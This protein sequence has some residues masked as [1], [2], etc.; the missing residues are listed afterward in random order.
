MSENIESI[1]LV[2]RESGKQSR[3]LRRERAMQAATGDEDA[4]AKMLRDRGLVLRERENSIFS[5]AWIPIAVIILVVGLFNGR[6]TA[7]LA[8]GFVLLIVVGVSALWKR[9]ALTG[10]FYRR[11]FDHSRVFP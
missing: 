7:L 6:N 2:I 3:R 11:S 10:V 5:D 1:H 8:L 4:L 9:A